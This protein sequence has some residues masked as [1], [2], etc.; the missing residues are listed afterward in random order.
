MRNIL[1]LIGFLVVGFAVAG[2]FFGWYQLTSEPSPDGHRKFNVDVNTKKIGED[3]QKVSD[4]I[5]N[6]TKG[7]P[8]TPAPAPSNN[9]PKDKEVQRTGFEYTP[10]GTWIVVPP[11]AEYKSFDPAPK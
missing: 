8:S 5:S 6:Q 11:K 3:E 7:T 1:A 9:P 4:F 10:E 2:Y